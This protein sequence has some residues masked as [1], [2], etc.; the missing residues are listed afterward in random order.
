VRENDDAS[1][2]LHQRSQGG[3]RGIDA[4]E[5]G[6]L[7]VGIA[8]TRSKGHVQILAHE[9]AFAS[10]VEVVEGMKVQTLLG[11]RSSTIAVRSESRH[12]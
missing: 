9:D 4:R 5:V 3:D 6:N 12:E 1:S 10:N 8:L 11:S 7:H 2:A